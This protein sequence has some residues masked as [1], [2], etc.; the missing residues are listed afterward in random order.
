[1]R[2]LVVL[3]SRVFLRHRPRIIA[4]YATRLPG[5]EMS[6]RSLFEDLSEARAGAIRDDAG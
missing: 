6:R 4:E 5:G 1:L 2:P 3:G